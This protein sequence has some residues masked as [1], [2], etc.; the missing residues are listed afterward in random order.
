VF[1]W[2]VVGEVRGPD[3]Q[4]PPGDGARLGLGGRRV[5]VVVGR[6]RVYADI[7]EN[8]RIF[9]NGAASKAKG[10]PPVG[11]RGVLTGRGA[12]GGLGI[13]LCCGLDVWNFHW[14]LEFS[15]HALFAL[16]ERGIALEWV[17][18]VAEAPDLRVDDPRDPELER[19]YGR[20]PEFGG[21]VLRVVLN[22]RVEPWRVVSVYF[23]RSMKGKL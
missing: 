13:G 9:L 18:R 14:M 16:G 8:I 3:K 20:V 17:E 6:F 7:L 4:G 11:F 2:V 5:G 21:R 19:F 12:D 23:D 15:E 22:T 1:F 10:I